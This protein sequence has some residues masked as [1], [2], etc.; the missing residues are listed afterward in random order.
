MR[1]RLTSS[2]RAS[3]RRPGLLSLDVM[4]DCCH[5][6]FCNDP[7]NPRKAYDSEREHRHPERTDCRRA[8]HCRTG[9]P[10][11]WPPRARWARD[12]RRGRWTHPRG[13]RLERGRDLRSLLAERPTREHAARTRGVVDGRPSGASLRPPARAACSGGGL[14]CRPSRCARS[15]SAAGSRSCAPAPSRADRSAGSASL[16]FDV[17]EL[18]PEQLLELLEGPLG[19]SVEDGC[20]PHRLGA[21]AVLAQVVDKDAVARLY[22]DPLGSELEDL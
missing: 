1:I 7:S 19:P 17:A 3:Y 4:A 15:T 14:T 16:R 10:R 21:R 2:T 6:C 5:Y 11:R 20:H 22:A 12:G 18:D 13:S 9:C 8:G